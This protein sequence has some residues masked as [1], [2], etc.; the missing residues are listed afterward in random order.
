MSLSG[1]TKGIAKKQPNS[2]VKKIGWRVGKGLIKESLFCGVEKYF[3]T[4]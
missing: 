1:H 2:L 4:D 3:S